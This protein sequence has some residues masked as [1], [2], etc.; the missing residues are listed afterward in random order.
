MRNL[1]DT[2][3]SP[4]EC[5]RHMGLP[6]TS[7]NFGPFQ[8]VGMAASYA[9]SMQSI[10]LP[11]LP[12]AACAEAFSRAGYSQRIILASMDVSKF[13]QVNQVRSKWSYLAQLATLPK[14]ISLASQYPATE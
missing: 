12:P 7:V 2:N 10:G 8:E 13:S 1:E 5:F 11:A 4:E 9:A 3:P 14:V 6:S